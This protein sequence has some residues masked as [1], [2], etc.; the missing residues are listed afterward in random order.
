[1]PGHI[2]EG[3]IP[4]W[5]AEKQALAA[6]H[7]ATELAV[8][9]FANLTVFGAE[10]LLVR[11]DGGVE[12]DPRF[13]TRDAKI[14]LESQGRL[15]FDPG[16]RRAR[17]IKERAVVFHARGSKIYG[18]FLIDMAPK[19]ALIRRA[20]HDLRQLKFLLC[21]DT[22]SW[23]PPML[24]AL[25]GIAPEQLIF[26]DPAQE[27]VIVEQALA[28]SCCRGDGGLH[29]A[30]A[31]IFDELAAAAAA[32]D[33][34]WPRDIFIDRRDKT[35]HASF[36]RSISN[37]ENLVEIARRQRPYGLI[38]PAKLSIGGQI[39][40]FR[41]AETVIGEYG[42][43]L[44]NAVFSQNLQICL[45]LGHINMLQSSICALRGARIG[46]MSVDILQKDL[47]IDEARFTEFVERALELRQAD[48]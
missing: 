8:Y 25:F 2:T 4:L 11:P 1:M 27:Y 16:A 3:W 38:D 7:P 21:A 29:P 36:N 39:A 26:F 37:L 9:E 13:L 45:C 42:S 31:G 48:D 40:L 17:V 47:T 35:T 14:L 24:Q 32:P 12:D 34:D 5:H 43:A 46:F 28:A 20:G 44:H 18:H 33:Q 15:G 23:Q 10:G 30:L 41:Q 6:T 19:I 22:P